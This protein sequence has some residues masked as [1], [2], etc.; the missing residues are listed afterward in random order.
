M[1]GGSETGSPSTLSSTGSPDWRTC[2]TSAG[3]VPSPGCGARAA[4]SSSVRMIPTEPPHLGERLATGLLDGEQ[5]LTLALLLRRQPPADGARLHRH[6]ADR[7]GKHVVQLARDPV[8]L[9]RNREPH[10]LLG[11]VRPLLSEPHLLG[12]PR[13]CDREHEDTGE[14]E[15]E[16]ERLGERDPRRTEDDHPAG[17]QH[18]AECHSGL[19]QV[20]ERA[21]RPGRQ[22][23]DEEHRSRVVGAVRIEQREGDRAGGADEPG[24]ET[25]PRGERG[26]HRPRGTPSRPAARADGPR[27]SR[28]APVSTRSPPPPPHR[29][30]SRERSAAAVSR[31]DGSQR[32]RERHRP[33]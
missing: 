17:E 7:V 19:A 5:R 3:S 20:Q 2:S 16:P 21:G 32:R 4:V 22:Q 12:P 24:R 29:R 31:W 26:A 25:G 30:R 14:R 13:R 28:P 9:L 6:H 33:R 15:A 18:R 8:P 23:E 11:P 27:V 10:F 1:P